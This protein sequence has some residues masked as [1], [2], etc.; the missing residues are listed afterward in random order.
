MLENLIA[1]F[2]T[3]VRENTNN[4]KYNQNAVWQINFFKLNRKVNL[5]KILR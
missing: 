4:L 5:V 2:P 1:Y 3:N